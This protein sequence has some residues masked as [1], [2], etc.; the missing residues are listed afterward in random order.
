VRGRELVD[1]PAAI[2]IGVERRIS[3]APIGAV[4]L[5]NNP[6]SDSRNF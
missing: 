1:P 4:G 2:G 5:L 3:N 6:I